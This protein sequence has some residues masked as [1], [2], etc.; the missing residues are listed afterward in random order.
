M[1]FRAMLLAA[2]VFSGIAGAQP[3]L[4]DGGVIN[5]A[6]FAKGQAVTPGSIVAIYGS[7]LAATT[8]AGSTVPLSTV[9][10]DT[11]VTING[12]AA[13]L[14]FVSEGQVNAQLPWNLPASGTVNVVLSRGSTP[15]APTTVSL[16]PFAPAVFS[17]PNGAGW[18]VAIN[19]A[20]A[21]LAAP[22]G[23]IPGITTHPAKAG[24]ALIVYA[25]GLGAV[26]STPANGAASLDMLRSTTT[27]PTVLI[28]SKPAD[29]KFSG[30]TP[31]F[32]GVNQINVVVP[33]GVSGTVPLQVQVGGI[34]ST[35]QVTIAVQ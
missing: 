15:S 12:I 8:L 11:S 35:D 24:D 20:D 28:G 6:S 29:V 1:S 31:Q 13:P 26:D 16:A 23:A 25:N 4:F 21:S 14:Y 17:I 22:P 7:G 30:L 5:G 32:P 18:A 9:I 33:E 34:I 3:V 2:C 19:N 10:G 27:V